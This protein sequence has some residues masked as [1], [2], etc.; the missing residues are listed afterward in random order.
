MLPIFLC[1]QSA[2][3]LSVAGDEETVRLNL[4]AA[5]GVSARNGSASPLARISDRLRCPVCQGKIRWETE[6]CS[7]LNP[8]CGRLFRVIDDVPLLLNR[9]SSVF[10]PS[11]V[12]PGKSRFPPRSSSRKSLWASRLL[13]AI[14]RN[15][16]A[17]QNYARF[18]ELLQDISR[19]PYVLVIGGATVGAGLESILSL[20]SINFVESDVYVSDR[21]ALV[22]DA[23]DIPFEDETFDGVIA[24]AVLEHVAD[25]HRCVEQIHRV[26]KTGGAVYA[27]TPFM[28]QVHAGGH[29]FTRFTHV[30][31]R[32]LFRNFEEIS[33]GV[34]CG[35][36]M[37]LAWAYQY[38]LLSFVRSRIARRAAI[39]FA[40]V[41]GFWLKYLDPYLVRQPGAIDAASALYF[42]G[43]KSKRSL[44][45][46]EIISHYRGLQV[47]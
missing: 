42:L 23:H 38:F 32:R 3:Q 27:D 1:V 33:S 17:K 44:S 37:A 12:R 2:P 7:C 36:A 4:P 30:G 28:Q 22:S 5:N 19:D 11:D 35:P 29:D 24:Q 34:S 25:P 39:A 46:A 14:G 40:R 41:T 16:R 13:P 45:D 15:I 26:L 47:S 43:R 8:A 20:P 6:T 18:A 10:D 31:Q 9:E 21:T